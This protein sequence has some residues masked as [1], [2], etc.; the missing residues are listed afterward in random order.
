MAEIREE[1]ELAQK[2]FNTLLAETDQELAGVGVDWDRRS[3][4]LTATMTTQR[5]N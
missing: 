5:L 3:I 1:L 4:P 2:K